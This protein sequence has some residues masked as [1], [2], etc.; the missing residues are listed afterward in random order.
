MPIL[1]EWNIFEYQGNTTGLTTEELWNAKYLYDSAYHP[2]TGEKMILIGR[3]SAQVPC[4]MV[5]TGGLMT[6]YKSTPQVRWIWKMTKD[7]HKLFDVMFD[8]LYLEL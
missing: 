5:I 8:I 2:D 6:F 1:L 7:E 4:N 3:M